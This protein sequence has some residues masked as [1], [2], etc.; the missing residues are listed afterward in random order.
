[1]KKHFHYIGLF[2][3][4]VLGLLWTGCENIDVDDEGMPFALRSFADQYFQGR[5]ISDYRELPNGNYELTISNGPTMTVS[6]IPSTNP[7][8]QDYANLLSYNGQGE[9]MPQNMAYNFFPEPLYDYIDGLESINQI[10]T[11]T[12]KNNIYTVGLLDTQVIYDS[13]SGKITET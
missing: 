5:G 4:S 12:L 1:M 10:Y 2:L 6:I 8:T 3:V 13:S 9:T 11:F 7:I